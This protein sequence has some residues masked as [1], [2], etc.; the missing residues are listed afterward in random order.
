M[1]LHSTNSKSI[2]IL[3]QQLLTSYGIVILHFCKIL[4][5]YVRKI[6]TKLFRAIFFFQ[7]SLLLFRAFLVHLDK[8]VVNRDKP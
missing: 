7:F 4:L 3:N 5:K 2:A 6:M 8:R 1:W